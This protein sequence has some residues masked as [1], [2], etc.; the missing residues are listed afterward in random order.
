MNIKHGATRT[1]YIFK[2]VVIK[3]PTTKEYRL[4][5]RGLLANIQEGTFSKTHKDL[6]NVLYHNKLGLFLIMERADVISNNIDWKDFENVLIEKYKDDP[7]KEFLLS[8]FKPSNWGY[9]KK[10]LVKIDYGN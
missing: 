10:N 3:I 6:A 1:V 9:V 4:F 8:D 5:L 2:N 7:M